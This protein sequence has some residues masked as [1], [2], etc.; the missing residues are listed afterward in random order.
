MVVPLLQGLSSPLVGCL[1]TVKDVEDAER[2]TLPSILC[3]RHA[4]HVRWRGGPAPASHRAHAWQLKR[5]W[6]FP[7]SAD[8]HEGSI[9]AVNSTEPVLL[10]WGLG[11]FTLQAPS[12]MKMSP[13]LTPLLLPCSTNSS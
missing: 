9:V 10:L 4:A 5:L 6:L 3:N 13:S 8:F 12:L 11:I 7:E 2:S 1:S